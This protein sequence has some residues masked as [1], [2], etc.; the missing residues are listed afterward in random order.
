M[1]FIQ[2]FYLSLEHAVNKRNN[3]CPVYIIHQGQRIQQFLLVPYFWWRLYAITFAPK[4]AKILA[5][6]DPM[7]P[8][9]L[10]RQPA[11]SFP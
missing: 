4:P 7:F 2:H 1:F 6:V 9:P 5:A 3:C 11:Y 10:S 8:V